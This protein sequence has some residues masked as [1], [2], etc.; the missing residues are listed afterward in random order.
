MVLCLWYTYPN[1]DSLKL[2]RRRLWFLFRRNRRLR[3]SANI[4]SLSRWPRQWRRRRTLLCPHT[5]GQ[6]FSRSSILTNSAQCRRHPQN[7]GLDD[8]VS[9]VGW[10]HGRHGCSC[11]SSTLWIPK[12]I[13]PDWP[14]YPRSENSQPL[15]PPRRGTMGYQFPNQ[16]WTTRQAL[17]VLS[18]RRGVDA[19]GSSTRN[20]IRS[21]VISTHDQRPEN[22]RRPYLEIRGWYHYCWGRSW[23]NGQPCPTCCQLLGRVVFKQSDATEC[24]QM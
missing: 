13:R 14:R 24:G 23:G 11:V 4:Y 9:S 20:Q 21:L 15:H 3:T 22:H 17:L 12:G 16:L 7:S 6:L 19:F 10:N 2:G 5:L 18:L 8:Y 1:S